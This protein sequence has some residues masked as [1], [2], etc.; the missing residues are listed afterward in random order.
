M[1]LLVWI[2]SACGVLRFNIEVVKGWV[3]GR[4][5]LVAPADGAKHGTI[6]TKY[7]STLE[8]RKKLRVLVL[9]PK[10]VEKPELP[11]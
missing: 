2:P 9:L 1:E 7:C 5:C 10:D 8:G 11:K 4:R 6:D 3:L